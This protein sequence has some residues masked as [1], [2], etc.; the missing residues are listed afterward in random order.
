M[1]GTNHI[2]MY[3]AFIENENGAAIPA[4]TP[5]QTASEVEAIEAATSLARSH[6][7]AIAWKR[8][9][10]PA[11]GEIGDPEIIYQAGRVGDFD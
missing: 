2:F 3:S 11:I 10:R 1:P 7:G 8:D 9:A 4:F 6:L 5:R